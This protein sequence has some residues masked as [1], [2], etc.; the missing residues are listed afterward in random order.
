MITK[1]THGVFPDTDLTIG[2]IAID[3]SSMNRMSLYLSENQHDALV[4]HINGL[5][6]KSVTQLHGK[7]VHLKMTVSGACQVFAGYVADVRPESSSSFGLMNKSPFQQVEVICMGASYRMRG[8]RSRSWNGYRLSDIAK[9]MAYTYGFDLDAPNDSSIHPALLQTNESDWQFLTRYANDLGYSVNVHG[10]HMH[11]Y[12]PYKALS[13][14][15]SVYRLTTIIGDK[16]PAV[17]SPGQILEFTGTFSHRH[18]DGDYKRADIPVINPTNS[19]YD[20]ASSAGLAQF[21][22]RSP[23]FADNYAEAQRRLGV[24]QK[25]RYDYYADVRVV[26]TVSCV[27]GGVVLVDKYEGE[28]DKYWYVQEVKHTVHS[29]A[30]FTDLKIARNINSELK[31]TNTKRLNRKLK[32]EYRGGAWLSPSRTAVVYE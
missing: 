30:F 29:D 8:S 31:N 24:L 5:P 23:E 7:P 25:D 18:I 13:R 28:F 17:T 6:P 3:Y 2:D 32:S 20:V 19:V 4:V 26:G 1:P 11:V 22:H 15:N 14:Q 12:D 21:P 10:T 16:S 9:D 27:P